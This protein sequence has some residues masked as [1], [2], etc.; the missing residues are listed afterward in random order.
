MGENDPGAGHGN[1]SAGTVNA[2]GVENITFSGSPAYTTN[3]GSRAVA[4]TSSSLALSFSGSE[5]GTRSILS[6]VNNFGFELW[7][8]SATSLGSHCL[9]YNGD[10]GTSGWGLYIFDGNFGALFGGVTFLFSSAPVVAGTWTHVALVCDD[11]VASVYVDGVVVS[12]VNAI[13][14]PPSGI[15]AMAGNPGNLGTDLFEGLMDELRVFTFS[16]GQFSTNDLN[17]AA[18]LHITTGTATNLTDTSATLQGVLEPGLAAMVYFQ[19]G[20]TASYGTTTTATSAPARTNT[21]V[22]TKPISGLSAGTTYHFRAVATNG[23]LIS[24]GSDQIFTTL[25]GAPQATTFPALG[26][27]TN[28]ATLNGTVNPNNAATTVYFA[29]GPTTTY[30]TTNIIGSIGNGSN[31]V[32]VSRALTGLTAGT[33][34]HYRVFASNSIASAA[35]SD[36][37]FFTANTLTNASSTGLPPLG[38]TFAWGDY[39]NDGRLDFAT[40]GWNGTSNL[41]QLWKNNGNGTFTRNFSVPGPVPLNNAFAWG[42]YDNDGFLDFIVMGQTTTNLTQI[43]RNLGN[44][45]FS[46]I[47]AGIT[48]VAYGSVAWGDFNNDGRLDI[49]LC[50]HNGTNYVAQIWRNNGS[51]SFSD[52]NAGLPPLRDGSV[53]WGD[54]DGDGRADLLV[55]GQSNGVPICQIWRNLGNNTFS[56]INAGLT[57]VWRSAVAWGDYDNDGKLDVLLSGASANDGLGAPTNVVCQVWR[58]AGNGVFANINAGFPGIMSGS[59]AFGDYENSGKL[60]VLLM[61]ITNGG[62]GASL[63]QLWRQTATGYSNSTLV[64]PAIGSGMAAW[65][66]SDNNGKLDFFLAGTGTTQL[67]TNRTGISN[68]APT[69][70]TG[71]TITRNGSNSVILSWNSATD[72]ETPTNG[73]TFNV[74]LGTNA[75]GSQIISPQA[76]TAGF[77]RLPQLGNAGPRLFTMVTNLTPGVTSYWSVQ[78]IDS[79]FAG[80]AFATEQSFAIVAPVVTTLNASNITKTA[81]S[82]YGTVN[83]A[84]LPTVAWFEWG[85]STSYGNKTTQ[86]ILG[87]GTNAL[88]INE[89]LSGLEANATY[90]FRCVASNAVGVTLGQP[91]TFSTPAYYVTDLHF[92]HFGEND[93]GAVSGG[94]ATNAQDSI[95]GQDLVLSG[96]PTY[97]TNVSPSAAAHVRSSLALNMSNGTAYGSC[98]LLS[99]PTDNFGVEVWVKPANDTQSRTIVYNGNGGTSGWGIL[100]SGNVYQVLFGSVAFFGS[101][102][103]TPNQWTHL[104]LVCDNGFSTFYMNGVSYGVLGAGPIP[105]SGAFGMGTDGNNPS[106]PAFAGWIDELRVFSFAPGGFTLNEL[107]LNG[108]GFPELTNVI[109]SGNGPNSVT[110]SATVLPSGSSSAAWFEYG[111]TAGYGSSTSKNPV[112]AG[113]PL[114]ITNNLTGLTPN[115]V[116]HF[117]AVATNRLGTDFGADNTF[118]S[119]TIPQATTLGATI[120][121][122]TN[123]MVFATVNPGSA[124]TTVYFEYGST[125][126]YGNSST[127]IV[128]SAGGG[129]QSVSNLL[130]GFAPISTYHYRVVATNAAG[131]SIGADQTFTT[132]ALPPLVT[133]QSPF[134]VR[135]PRATFRASV[136]PNG[137][138]SQVWFEYGLTTNYGNLSASSSVPSGAPLDVATVVSN[139]TINTL[140]HV[141][142]VASNVIQTTFGSDLTFVTPL[143]SI[144]NVLYYRL[145]ENDQGAAVGQLPLVTRNVAGTT[146]MNVLHA[147]GALGASYSADVSAVAEQRAGSALSLDVNAGFARTT[148]DGPSLTDNFG[149]EVWAKPSGLSGGAHYIASNGGP[150]TSGWNISREGAN[151]VAHVV[152]RDGNDAF[153]GGGRIVIVTVGSAPVVPDQWSHLALVRDNGTTTFYVNGVPSGSTTFEP[154]RADHFFALASRPD[155]STGQDSFAG[156]ID[157]ARIFSFAPGT[158]QTND[159]LLNQIIAPGIVNVE[160]NIIGSTSAALR[161]R[162]R[163]SVVDAFAWFEYGPTTNYGSFTSTNLVPAGTTL[164]I[165]NIVSG[166]TANITNYFRVVATNSVGLISSNGASFVTTPAKPDVTVVGVTNSNQRTTFNATIH[167]N[168]AATLVWFEYGLTTNY[169]SFSSTSSVPA[170]VSVTRSDFPN[171]TSPDTYHFRVVAANSVGTFVG[172]DIPFNSLFAYFRLGEIDLGAG[173]GVNSSSS[174]NSIGTNRLVLTGTVTYDTNVSSIAATRAGSSFSLNFADTSSGTATLVSTVTDNFV[175]EVWVKP[176]RIAGQSIVYNGNGANNGWGIQ[177]NNN[178]YRALFGGVVFFGSAPVIVGQWTHLAIVRE[179]GTATFYAD[180]VAQ[181]STAS[182]LNMPVGSFAVGG[183]FAGLIDEVRAFYIAPG[184]NLNQLLYVFSAAPAITSQ[185]ISNVTASGATLY[186]TIDPNGDQ[187][188]ALFKSGL[189]TNYG[190]TAIVPLAS[191]TGAQTVNYALTGLQAGTRYHYGLSATNGSGQT[192]GTNLS[193]VTLDVRRQISQ[194]TQPTPGQLRLEFTGGPDVGYK[195]LGT[196]NLTLPV[197]QWPVIGTAS[198]LSNGNFQF[199]FPQPTNVPQ[200]FYMLRSP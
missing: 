95:G 188:A 16:A 124:S 67:W 43:W 168:G 27:I 36:V 60:A 161:A 144:T 77:R 191:T 184:F 186:A 120:V 170:G 121:S 106:A 93:T 35:G 65:G 24:M 198:Y 127:S 139:L 49:A 51:N 70:P 79:A 163:P 46:N 190:N 200:S 182:S 192:L 138:D 160:A 37:T 81:A 134:G 15:L 174:S 150:Q 22:V 52:I 119:A 97:T 26:V 114:S 91:Q 132:L 141:R 169:G 194:V 76:S 7:V 61:G 3:V 172:N 56:N 173:Q 92:Y 149:L 47:N 99:A 136:D 53:A 155:S 28:Q 107:L 195:I 115:L 164:T 87:S 73:L 166:L 171:F 18:Q 32:A 105:A 151:F 100:Q 33:T 68:Q 4:A 59:V 74:R 162:V 176:A 159:L 148:V 21:A 11:G 20:L 167:P 137:A 109:A 50:G 135:A 62:T 17:L 113:A 122:Q 39:D 116:Y 181:G 75:G 66:D 72:A 5:Y 84:G 23:T 14:N 118:F 9:A 58:N 112:P 179:N 1:S 175:L 94:V 55:S 178:E 80:S 8:N 6:Q 111:T 83:P 158:F 125:T 88:S 146:N 183:N 25:G 63:S 69:V 185:S 128:L 96:S 44:N 102:P 13:P 131:A 29:H 104:A 133:I 157:E 101:A 89:A 180:G 31:A 143:L 117:R 19:Y 197:T 98:S 78:A 123:A 42:D 129:S 40:V 153:P 140:Y 177:Q 45:T 152:G 193:F 165:T 38:G 189:T 199:T 2:V 10:P 86:Q 108:P 103:V 30:G 34:Y 57:G 12:T 54:Y 147:S 41:F 90:Y 85:L 71:L 130:T 196:T 156:W 82:M 145:G 142:P 154:H 48:G 64:V 187:T 126:A 110:L